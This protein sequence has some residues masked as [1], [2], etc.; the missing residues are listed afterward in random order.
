MAKN[1]N[2]SVK[3]PAA[4]DCEGVVIDVRAQSVVVRLADAEAC[5]H[6]V[7]KEHCV[8]ASVKDRLIEVAARGLAL[9]DRV[10][11]GVRGGT[12][13]GISVALYLIPTLLIVVG[14]FAGA[15]SGPVFFNITGDNGAFY[16][17]VL[18]ILLSLAFVHFY[19]GKR[20]GGGL[21]LEKIED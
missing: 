10:R 8:L 15:L 9:G 21:Y 4:F 14:A 1:D 12:K 5:R 7:G 3:Q 6:C 11:I 17:V 18:G 2:Q 20:A 19:P 13:L 16:G